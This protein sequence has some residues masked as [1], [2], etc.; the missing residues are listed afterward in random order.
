MPWETD[1]STAHLGICFFLLQ[2]TGHVQVLHISHIIFA[3]H[4]HTKKTHTEDDAL[5]RTGDTS[6]VASLMMRMAHRERSTAPGSRP[7]SHSRDAPHKRA[8][9]TWASTECLPSGAHKLRAD[10]STR[11]ECTMSGGWRE[12]FKSFS[13][14]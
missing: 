6:F 7:Q 11:L 8:R 2:I 9:S 5:A 14:N 4:T 10:A 13:P 3:M 1:K 12:P